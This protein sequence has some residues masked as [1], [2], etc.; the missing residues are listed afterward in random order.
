MYHTAPFATTLP[1]PTLIPKH[2]SKKPRTPEQEL[3]DL[4]IWSC[5]TS[6]RHTML[7]TRCIS[8]T[9]FR[10][11]IAF[12][13]QHDHWHRYRFDFI[14]A[15]A[16]KLLTF[17]AFRHGLLE[18]RKSATGYVTCGR[19]K[20]YVTERLGC[21]PRQPPFAAHRHMHIYIYIDVFQYRSM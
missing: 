13:S 18:K 20:G 15:W 9:V 4:E 16:T 17:S 8:V 11:R 7:H 10:I 19:C 12:A 2:C 6:V 21:G 14:W 1:P 5:G 3:L